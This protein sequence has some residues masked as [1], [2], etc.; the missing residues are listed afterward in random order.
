MAKLI[1]KDVLL[2]YVSGGIAKIRGVF[3]E[4]PVLL[5]GVM[6][7]FPSVLISV[8]IGIWM[9]MTKGT[10]SLNQPIQPI[11]NWNVSNVESIADETMDLICNNH[12]N[13]RTIG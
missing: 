7:I 2:E 10:E 1:E 13:I 11:G 8:L 4:N 12:T 6:L 5:A 9:V 3:R